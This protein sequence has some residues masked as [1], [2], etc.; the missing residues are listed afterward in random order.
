M[1]EKEP[2]KEP[3]SSNG[4]NTYIKFTGL[5]FQMIAII[6]AF[7]YVGYRIDASANHQTKWVTALLS[8]I[9]VFISF[10]TIFKSLKN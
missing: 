10:Y 7:A 9:G 8:L 5:A 4:P 3:V 6:G 1:A 2:K